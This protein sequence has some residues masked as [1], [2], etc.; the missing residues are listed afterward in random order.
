MKLLLG[1]GAVPTG[2]AYP[3]LSATG[4]RTAVAIDDRLRLVVS[5]LEPGGS[6]RWSDGHGEEALYVVDGSVVVDDVIV[7]AGGAV[8][9]HGGTGLRLTAPDGARLAHF[10]A[11]GT[12]GGGQGDGDGEVHLL[13]PGGRYRSVAPSGSRATWFADSTCAGCDVALFW[14]ARDTPGERGR[15]HSHTADEI[16]FVVDGAISLGAH[17]L[18]PGHGVLVPAGTRYA[19]TSGPAG[20][21]F[22]NYRASASLQHYEGD[23]EPMV[24]SGLGRGGEEVGDVLR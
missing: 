4:A 14:V 23:A 8:I 7:P 12:T 6:L 21:R 3:G 13:G 15:S 2:D 9:L 20:H 11:P 16:L 18:P 5:W 10:S 17:T 22:L 19:V 24:E 1:A